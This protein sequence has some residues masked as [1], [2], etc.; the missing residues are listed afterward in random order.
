MKGY[1]REKGD[2]GECAICLQALTADEVELDCKHK[3]HRG[4]ISQLR[5]FGVNEICPQCRTPLPLGP[6]ELWDKSVRRIARGRMTADK[7]LSRLHNEKAKQLL[8]TLITE[9][10][11]GARGHFG[12]GSILVTEND[13]EGAM[14]EFQEATKADPK[15]ADAHILLGLVMM[16]QR[17]H[18]A[19][20]Q[21]FR[22]AI[23]VETEGSDVGG[24][25]TFNFA[26]AHRSLGTLLQCNKDY[27]GAEAEYRAAI[28][29]SHARSTH[30]SDPEQANT[31][32]LLGRLLETTKKDYDGAVTQ[33]LKAVQIV[34]EFKIIP[35]FDVHYRLGG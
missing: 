31:H 8:Q 3:Y 1:I 22:E 25:Y 6:D 11:D 20:E 35:A 23:K 24:T 5:N 4:C 29:S 7:E 34:R 12:M 28:K 30:D 33:Y 19:A 9:E 27:A 13:A 17:Y 16:K 18:K 10:P 14:R 21:E 2:Q 26:L 32:Y 15:H